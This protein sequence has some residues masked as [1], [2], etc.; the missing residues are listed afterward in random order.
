MFPP[1]KPVRCGLKSE[2]E[3]ALV[4]RE[5]LWIPA[6][7][8]FICVQIS[9][10]ERPVYCSSQRH[11]HP[12]VQSNMSS[13]VNTKQARDFLGLGFKSSAKFCAGAI[14][15]QLNRDDAGHN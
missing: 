3:G 1:Y 14:T 2:K 6:E 8:E 7:G 4:A 12:R 13:N 10:C 5:S 11:F 9:L 15:R